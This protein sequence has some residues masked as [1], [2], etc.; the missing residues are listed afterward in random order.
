MAEQLAFGGLWYVVFLLSI[1]VHEAA[2]AWAAL[3][4]GDPTA[5]QTGQVTLDPRPH[6]RREPFGT[7]IMPLLTYFTMGWMMGWASAP[8]DPVWADRHPRRAAKMALAGPLANLLLAVLAGV[9]MHL[10]LQAGVFGRPDHPAFTAIV[11]AASP[12]FA[13]AVATFLSI[14]FVLNAL[15]FTFNLLPVPPLD[16]VRAITLFFPEN[17]ARRFTQFLH[18]LPMIQF[19]G[20]LVAWR[21]S[22]IILPPILSAAVDLVYGGALG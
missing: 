7:I 15:L 22:H 13:G 4:G 1:T 16:G 14:L 9:V 10:G 17:A 20:I 2:H 6:I 12:G 5:A 3:K 11:D 18:Q 8:Y 21:A 19:V